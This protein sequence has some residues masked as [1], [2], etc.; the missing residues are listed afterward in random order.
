MSLREQP[1]VGSALASP[2]A[3]AR[4]RDSREIAAPTRPVTRVPPGLLVVLGVQGVAVGWFVAHSWFF[5][6]DFLFLAQGRDSRLTLSYLR[7]PMF[8]HFSPVLRFAEWILAHSG[9]LSWAEAASVLV[10]L[11]VS[12]T[13]AFW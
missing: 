4:P 10:V 9:G 3:G 6:D 5:G 7:L 12:C 2:A 11:T 1:P 8:D 13:G